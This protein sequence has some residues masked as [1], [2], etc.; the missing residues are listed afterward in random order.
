MAP[1][2]LVAPK[3][4][5]NRDNGIP[6]NPCRITWYNPSAGVGSCGWQCQD[7]DPVVAISKDMMGP[8]V[9]FQT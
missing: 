6:L 4:A 5:P 8:I 9:R 7:N 2:G 3:S 1:I